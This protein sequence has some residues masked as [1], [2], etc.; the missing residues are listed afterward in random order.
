VNISSATPAPLVTMNSMSSTGSGRD[1]LILNHGEDGNRGSL[2]ARD[3]SFAIPVIK[4]LQEEW[5]H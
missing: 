3:P 2:F 4:R 5:D 1:S